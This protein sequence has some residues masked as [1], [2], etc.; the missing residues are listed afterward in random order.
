MKKWAKV[1]LVLF[2]VLCSAVTSFADPGKMRIFI[3]SSYHREYLWSQ[4]TNAGVCAAL[5]EFKFL[6]NKAQGEEL[7]RNDFVETEKVVI[8]KAWMDTKRKNAR[9]EIAEAAA[10]ITEEIHEFKPDLILLGDDNAANYIGNE[11]VDTGIPVVF[12]GGQCRSHEVWSRRNSGV[13]R[14]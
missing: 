6:D 1:F 3:V 4:D 13:S 10:K 14:P 11:F 9:S 5:L 2:F 8:R 12:W 7:T